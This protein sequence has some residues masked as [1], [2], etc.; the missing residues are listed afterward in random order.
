[1]CVKVCVCVSCYCTRRYSRFSFKIHSVSF[2]FLPHIFFPFIYY[3]FHRI[4]FFYAKATKKKI[5]AQH[6]MKWRATRRKTRH[7]SRKRVRKA[8]KQTTSKK[9]LQRATK[10]FS[11]LLCQFSDGNHCETGTSA[12]FPHFLLFFYFILFF[13]KNARV[14]FFR[15]RFLFPTT[16]SLSVSLMCLIKII[17]VEFCR[18]DDMLVAI[19][20]R[21]KKCEQNEWF[22]Q[23]R[24]KCQ[25]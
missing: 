14:T 9:K 3:F 25:N 6:L 5:C 19:I 7:C 4:D 24:F 13:K 22:G 16:F 21:I 20:L 12:V 17:L 18:K 1:M 11:E 10:R 8:S 15:R 2:A 23:S